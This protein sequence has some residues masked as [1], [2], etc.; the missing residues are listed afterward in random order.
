LTRAGYRR[1]KKILETLH[2]AIADIKKTRRTN[3]SE[4]FTIAEL[5]LNLFEED[6][7]LQVPSPEGRRKYSNAKSLSYRRGTKG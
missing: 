2:A 4:K 7:I 5:I 1:K 3:S 6:L